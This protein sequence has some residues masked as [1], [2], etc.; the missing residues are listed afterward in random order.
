MASWNFLSRT[1]AVQPPPE[2]FASSTYAG[3]CRVNPRMV[4]AEDE[5]G[6][7][8]LQVDRE[9]VVVGGEVGD[10]AALVTSAG[11]VTVWLAAAA[12]TSSASRCPMRSAWRV[13]T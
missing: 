10:D 7:G 13:A 2:C 6:E 12:S 5:R 8:L 1:I 9:L 4:A 3:M 11:T